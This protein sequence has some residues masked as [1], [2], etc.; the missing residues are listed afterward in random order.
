MGREDVKV[1]EGLMLR[2]A[3]PF[4]SLLRTASCGSRYRFGLS[5]PPVR[6]MSRLFDKK[7]KKSPKLSRHQ[8][9]LGIP[10]NIVASPLGFRV[11][12]DIDPE[13]ERSCSYYDP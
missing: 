12:L 5:L 6:S 11:D 8:I 13:G 10:A 3:N 7:S 1:F 9:F 2:A 4:E